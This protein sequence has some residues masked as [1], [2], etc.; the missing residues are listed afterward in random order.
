MG[1]S[2]LWRVARDTWQCSRFLPEIAQ[3]LHL[4]VCVLADWTPRGEKSQNTGFLGPFGLEQP[5]ALGEIAGGK[6]KN[7]NSQT[8]TEKR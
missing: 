5:L 4:C 2:V 3:L 7:K 1:V 8:E 6:E